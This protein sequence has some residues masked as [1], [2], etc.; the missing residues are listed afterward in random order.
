MSRTLKFPA[1]SRRKFI[2]GV[3]AAAALSANPSRSSSANDRIGIGVIGCGGRGGSHI[4]YLKQLKEEGE[5]VEI[6]A[7]CD[8]YRPRL[9]KAESETGA[10]GYM[11]HQ[12]LLQ[13]ANVDAVLIASP[14]HWHGYQLLDA[15]Q[16]GKDA[17]I[18]KPITHWRQVGLIRRMTDA[19]RETQRIV[20]VGVQ[21]MSSSAWGQAANLI[22]Q[23][24]I[25]KPLQAQGGY[26]RNGEW[27]ER[28]PID[29]PNAA[30]GD[31]LLWETFL[32][33]CPQRPY[34]VSRFFQWRM[35]WDYAGG[36][37][38]DLFPHTFTPLLRM[39]GLTY[40]EA[41]S[42]SGGRFLYNHE[43]EV[44][45]TFN[46]MMDYPQG[47]SIVLTCTLGNNHGVPTVIRG[48]EGTMTFNDENIFI[49][50][51]PNV[52]RPQKVD[53]IQRKESQL[54]FWRNFLACCR[55]RE[56]PWAPMALAQPVQTTLQMGVMALRERKVVRFDQKHF[57]I[58]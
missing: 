25:G 57:Q 12:E 47:V 55:S 37:S 29:D 8:V 4:H 44:P 16:A 56:E 7:V 46:M 31:D 40:P 48:A 19:V 43:R 11:L 35:Y 18:E 22:Q 51:Q 10:K 3:G 39:L 23:G 34:S 21:C 41:A 52:D 20:Q 53:P 38:T 1:V 28:M 30:P 50:P 27:G 9:Q 26:F 54:D 36:P 5:A 2:A 58:V 45:D 24:A 17:Y 33:D 6:T 49:T 42:A 13:D 32:G 14:D 15:V